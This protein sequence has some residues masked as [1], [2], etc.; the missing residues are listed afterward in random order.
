MAAMKAALEKAHAKLAAAA[1]MP[2]KA[3]E[4]AGAPAEHEKGKGPAGPAAVAS[5]VGAA[6]GAS[7]RQLAA[8]FREML[9]AQKEVVGLEAEA[10][11]EL[12]ATLARAKTAKSQQKMEML[13][14]AAQLAAAV[15][16]GSNG[17][18]LLAEAAAVAVAAASKEAAG[19]EIP[20]GGAAAELAAEAKEMAAEA[21]ETAAEAAEL[22]AE[23]QRQAAALQGKAEELGAA[24]QR[25]AEETAAA[26]AMMNVSGGYSCSSALRGAA[27]APFL[28]LVQKTRHLFPVLTVAEAQGQ[29]WRL[30]VSI[31]R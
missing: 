28:P 31:G 16:A 29:P 2:E 11:R 3:G 14:A 30:Q 23:I 15:A 21:K 26:D 13:E 7:S 27:H 20:A 17:S 1:G 22:A 24:A 4:E 9:E 8:R 18:V 25:E 6:E 5:A 19:A 12:G 10:N